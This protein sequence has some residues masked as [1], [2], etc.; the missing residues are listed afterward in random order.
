MLFSS[1]DEAITEVD[2]NVTAK[3][4]EAVMS[5]APEWMPGLP[6]A[7]EAQEVPHYKK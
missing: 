5:V 7:A 2:Q 1:H 6:V 4:V 3:D